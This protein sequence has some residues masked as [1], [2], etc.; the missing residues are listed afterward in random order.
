M[1]DLEI[2]KIIVQFLNRE[3]SVDELNYLE[4]W[5]DT[6]KNIDVF[7]RFVEIEFLTTMCIEVFDVKNAK[8]L[9]NAKF[10]KAKRRKKVIIYQR[11]AVAASILII[12][13]L[14]IYTFSN[15]FESKADIVATENTIKTGKSK[16]ILT[17]ANGDQISLEKDKTYQTKETRGDGDKLL[18][19]QEENK[20]SVAANI[21]YHYLTIPRGGEYSL[22]LAD[23]TKILLNS[24]S[25]LKYFTRFIKGKPRNVELIYGEAYFD[26][27]PSS[28]FN[29]STFNVFSKGQK[30]RVLGTT[31]NVKAYNEEDFIATTLV[32][33]KVL[34]QKG[35]VKK[36]LWSNQ[37]SIVSEGSDVIIV[38]DVDVANEISWVHGLFTF[39]EETLDEMMKVLARW[40]NAEIIFEDATKKQFVFTGVLERTKSIDTILQIIQETSKTEIIFEINENKII[41][42]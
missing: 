13:S 5:L 38:V 35:K 39:E 3:A 34:V 40:Y 6:N 42:K 23:G 16:A 30:I 33:G 18:Y 7:N 22:V 36:T 17:L 9:V 2:K 19:N 24:D 10:K 14:S 11:I 28:K 1:N 32:E 29:G 25:K 4:K 8:E 27:S 12:I 15:V 21:K 26:V 31:F 41:V 37:Q 20:T